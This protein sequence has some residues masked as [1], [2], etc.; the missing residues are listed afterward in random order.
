MELF[1]NTNFDFLGK[2]WPFIILS[3]VLTAA[4]L[5]SLAVKGGPRCGL[6]FRGGALVEVTFAQRPPVDKVRARLAGKLRVEVQEEFGKPNDLIGTDVRDDA[7]LQ[8]ARQ[9]IIDSL[10][11]AFGSPSGGKYN[12]NAS[13][14]DA[15]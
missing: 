1:G 8:A 5:V 13:G 9:T 3:L 12:V 10:T 14:V 2:K 11:A 4:G 7:A 15:L 6:D